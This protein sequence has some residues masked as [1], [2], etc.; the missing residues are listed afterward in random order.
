MPS[1]S[2]I[3]RPSLEGLASHVTAGDKTRMSVALRVS[4]ACLLALPG[5]SSSFAQTLPDNEQRLQ[6]ALGKLQPQRPGV[7]DAYVIVAALDAD[8]VFNREAREAGRVLAKRFDAEGRTLV[9]AHDEGADKADAETSPIS[10]PEALDSVAA[11]MNPAEDVLVLYT[12]SHGS[13]GAGL[14]FKDP[15]Y[16]VGVIAPNQLAAMLDHAGFKNRLIILQACFSGQFVPVL[17]GPSTIIATAAADDRTSFGCQAGNDW[18]YFGDAL[19]NHAFRQPLPLDVQFRRAWAL[20]SAAESRDNLTP[21][22]PQFNIGAA[23]SKWLNALD[24]REPAATVPPV[25][26]TVLG[27]GK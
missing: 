4:V 24:Q 7:V 16:G 2:T 21:S 10:L 18:T 9:L 23:T 14:N 25:G 8:P 13:P 3:S 1:V 20:I 12:T 26:Q 17:K 6:A 27:L 11:K 22:N 19:I 5:A 15:A